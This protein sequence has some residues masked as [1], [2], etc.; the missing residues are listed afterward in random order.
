[1][2]L[3][4]GL[5][6]GTSMDAVDAAL[7]RFDGDAPLL[8]AHHKQPLP[9]EVKSTISR[10]A[11]GKPC[12]V[13]VIGT[14]DA[15]LGE[16]F[17]DAVLALL[18][19]TKISPREV[20]AIGSHGQTLF[21]SPSTKP[22]YSWQIGDPNIIA[23]RTGITTIADFRRRDMAAGGQGAPLVPAFHQAVFGKTGMPRAVV[24]IGGIANVT[25][26]P[27]D[28]TATRGFDTGPG[29]CLLDA[30]CEQH[31]GQSFDDGGKWGSGGE[32]NEMLLQQL[33]ADAYFSTAPPKSS[34]REYFNVEWLT[35]RPFKD[36]PQNIQATLC[37]LTAESIAMAIKQHQPATREV[38]VCGGG[39]HNGALMQQL[40]IRLGTQIGLDT[41]T[42]LG[43]D[44]GW[45]EA[46]AFA[47]LAKQTLE[48]R[49][50]NLPAVTGAQR[51]V[52]LGGIYWANAN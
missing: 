33:L 45:V 16:H 9:P 43:V 4:L 21:H 20:T 25:L 34:G 47:W 41:T 11:T 1:M 52:I 7:V 36:S 39:A 42:A 37:T 40:A 44:P 35:Q 8:I 15:Q 31:L 24:N 6:S 51:P 2:N 30:W 26:L 18:T 22:A 5:M 28:G 13:S 3:Y 27:G 46:M 49:P 17:A 32:I 50:G 10:L 29:N 38:F 14:L 12:A 23:E 19:A 48:H